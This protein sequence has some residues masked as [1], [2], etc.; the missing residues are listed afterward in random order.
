MQAVCGGGG[1][2]TLA[3]LTFLAVVLV[4]LLLVRIPFVTSKDKT[5]VL[6]LVGLLV[7]SAILGAVIFWANGWIGGE[8]DYF[9][10]F[11]LSLLVSGALG[12][13]VAL[14]T[15]RV[16][17]ARALFVALAGDVLIPGGL[18]ALLFA[19]IGIGTGCLD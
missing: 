7:V 15:H 14:T 16:S 10:R 12:V 9:E 6:T 19:A 11:L 1:N 5:E 17:V 4:W 2:D 13:G 8:R 18:V 3:L